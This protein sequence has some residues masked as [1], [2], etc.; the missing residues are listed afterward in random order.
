MARVL[1][2]RYF[3]QDNNFTATLKKSILCLEVTTS[4]KRLSQGRYALYCRYLRAHY[5][6]DRSLDSRSPSKTSTTTNTW[7]QCWKSER[8][9]YSRWHG[10]GW[11]KIARNYCTWGCGKDIVYQDF[12]HSK[13]WYIGM[14]DTTMKMVYNQLSP[15]IGLSHIHL[16][17]EHFHPHKEMLRWNGKYG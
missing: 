13:T 14:H 10:L 15:D 1:K 12:L 16:R 9:L 17:L 5:Y 11:T 4:W 3:P 6:L 8:F 7:H 2:A